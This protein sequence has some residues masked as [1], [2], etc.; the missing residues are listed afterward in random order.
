VFNALRNTGARPGD[1]VAVQ[2][3]GGLGHLGVQYAHEAGFETVALSRSPDKRD[4]AVDLGAD[5]FV[6]ASDEDPAEA[7]QRLGGARV[8]LCTAPSASAI[9]SVVG[10]LGVDGEAVVLGV[11]HDPIG[12]EA[13]QLIGARGSVS[14]WSS[15]HARDSQD[16]LEFSARR[17]ITPEIET[18]PLEDV[19]AAFER[20]MNNEARF[21]A[22]L[23][24]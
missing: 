19:D 7:L 15:G 23:E 4:F 13:T 8:V 16:T 24:P 10:G 11:P 12:V 18:Y 2:G 21:R 22:V 3:I 5:H 17:E 6:D 20:M 1:L 9:E 14:G